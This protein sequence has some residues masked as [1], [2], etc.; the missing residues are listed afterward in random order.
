MA[1]RTTRK[2]DAEADAVA[3][4]ALLRRRSQPDAVEML[5]VKQYRPPV[6][7]FT[8]ELPAGLID[9]GESAEAA[10]LRELREETGFVGTA[11]SKSGLLAMSPGLC[12]ESIK[13]VVAEVDL[14]APVNRAPEQSLEDGEHIHVVRVPVKELLP[15]LRAME[16]EGMIPF[17]GL[18]T[19]ALGLQ[20]STTI[21]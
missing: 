3:I 13:L 19:L 2:P 11:S 17:T 21:S 8:I 5:L 18:Y 14:D 12:D 1:S 9:P 16:S 10:A 20:L 7:S 4:L 15:A 6:D